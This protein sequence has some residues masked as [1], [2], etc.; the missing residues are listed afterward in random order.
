MKM[1]YKNEANKVEEPWA[2]T[3]IMG[4]KKL[5]QRTSVVNVS[6]NKNHKR[7]GTANKN[8]NRKHEHEHRQEQESQAQTN[9]VKWTETTKHE[10]GRHGCIIGCKCTNHE[11]VISRNHE[12]DHEN[13][14]GRMNIP[15]EQ[16]HK[17]RTGH[18]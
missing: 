7:E 10:Q 16:E 6:V 5:P 12:L 4:T 8:R 13:V 9:I 3:K 15:E 17:S 11:Q 14:E 2:R 1:Q 18:D